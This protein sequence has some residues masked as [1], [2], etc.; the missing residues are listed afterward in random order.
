MVAA[1]FVAAMGMVTD[2]EGSF[3]VVGVLIA[4]LTTDRRKLASTAA[5]ALAPP[6]LYAIAMLILIPSEFLYDWQHNL[7]RV[8]DA[9]VFVMGIKLGMNY[10]RFLAFDY[11]LPLGMVG[12]FLIP[13]KRARITLVLFSVAALFLTRNFQELTKTYLVPFSY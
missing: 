13:N 6:A 10:N 11:W 9:N 4:T 3:V 1:A 5:V 12:I 2:Q 8:N 7:G